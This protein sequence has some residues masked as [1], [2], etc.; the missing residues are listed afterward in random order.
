MKK[1]QGRNTSLRRQWQI[2]LKIN[3]SAN[4]VSKT[5][6]ALDH[7]V[8]KR[9]IFR[10]I[11]TLSSCGF[12]IYEY[13]DKDNLGQVC[14]KIVDN[15]KF[16]SINFDIE[17]LMNLFNLYY[18]I[19][20]KNPFFKNSFKS[21]FKKIKYSI[22]H[23]MNAFFKEADKIFFS[24]SNSQIVFN[25]DLEENIFVI[26]E[27]IRDN[28]KIVFNYFSMKTKN[29]KKVIISPLA[30]KYFNQNYYLAGHIKEK[31]KVYT[32]ACNRISNLNQTSQN[33]D[34]IK[35][36]GE[37]YFESG[38]GIYSG[39]TI[40]VKIKFSKEIS[41]FI[42]ER[43]WHKNQKF[44]DNKDG[45]TLLELPVNS[46]S[47]IKKMVLSY[48]RNATV[49]EPIELQQMIRSELKE[50]LESIGKICT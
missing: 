42:K 15:Y 44:A 47:E 18:S 25:E 43:I 34:K 4:G 6:L 3:N 24:D 8:S 39:E 5:E 41:P 29:I 31:D 26:F 9:T 11:S 13:F 1:E 21:F 27:A 37:K 10:D 30:I 49:V 36:D 33:R 50:M 2:L 46:L 23:E 17:E 22:G 12:P 38:F 28:K 20:N 16:P 19:V 14:Y 45:S 40:N 48:G 7:N 32:W 35:F